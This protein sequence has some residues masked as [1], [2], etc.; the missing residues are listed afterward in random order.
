MHEP[1]AQQDSHAAR[2]VR[3]IS[4]WRRRGPVGRQRCDRHRRSGMM[5]MAEAASRQSARDVDCC[6][7][8]TVLSISML[9]YNI[10]VDCCPS[11][12]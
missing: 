9:H 12:W 2:A 3:F 10:T 6:C 11:E 1:G 5:N 4:T 8:D 7:N